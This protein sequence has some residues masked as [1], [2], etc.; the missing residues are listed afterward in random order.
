MS[1]V[2]GSVRRM[3]ESPDDIAALQ[4]LMDASHAGATN[5]LRQIISGDHRMTA[6]QLVAA[7]EGM[8]VLT[9]ATVT[10]KGEPRV[11]AVDGHFLRGTWT[12]GTDGG[13]AKARHIAARPAVSVAHVDGERI[14]IFAHGTAIRLEAGDGWF[15]PTV[16]HWA[17]H[18]GSDPTTWNDDVRL[19][20]L[21]PTWLVAYR[22]E[23]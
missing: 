13:S 21:A 23:P 3:H 16:A 11:S 2:A 8:K 6:E 10:A 7:T 14:G 1:V 15:E 19:Y 22:G 9:I 4:R 18:Y 12:F 5:H 17:A 20:R